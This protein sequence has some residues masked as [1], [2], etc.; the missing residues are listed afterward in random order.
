MTAKST[1]ALLVLA[2]TPI[3]LAAQEHEESEAFRRHQLATFTGYG[4]VPQGDP[5]EGDP[6]GT[7]IVPTLGIDYNFWISHKFAVG[8]YNDFQLTTYVAQTSA[9][10]TIPREYAYV[11]ALVALYEPVHGLAFYAGP[12]AEIE[13]HE[14]F[15]VIKAGVEYAFARAG[16]WSTGVALGYD[17]RFGP[18]FEKELTPGR[19][20]SPSHAASEPIRKR[21]R[22]ANDPPPSATTNATGRRRNLR[23]GWPCTPSNQRGAGPRAGSTPAPGT[24][25][26]RSGGSTGERFV[27]SWGDWSNGPRGGG[28]RCGRLD[29]VPPRATE[30]GVALWLPPARAV[31][32]DR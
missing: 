15:F 4:W 9:D 18:G 2:T 32:A 30:A 25:S 12:G 11:G 13:K 1:L 21:W 19:W 14:N 3:P 5:H 29:A 28:N 31:G 20:G 26:R 16:R 24:G 22:S 8:F 6:D 17:V 7:V 23:V 10:T 27:E